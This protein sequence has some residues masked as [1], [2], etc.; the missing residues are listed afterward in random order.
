[1]EGLGI[2]PNKSIVDQFG[3]VFQKLGMMEKYTKLK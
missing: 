1:M 3:D 2:K